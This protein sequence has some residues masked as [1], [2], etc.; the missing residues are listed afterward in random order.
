MRRKTA[1]NLPVPKK[2][3]FLRAMGEFAKQPVFM[4]MLAAPIIGGLAGAVES[5]L[6]QARQ[7]KL[8][9]QSYKTMLELH[10][11]L[12]QRNQ[13]EV[14]RIYSSLHNASPAMASDPMVAG[15]WVDNIVE[16]KVP[17]MNSHQGLLNAVKDLA[18][19]QWQVTQARRAAAGDNR[20]RNYTENQILNIGKGV[21][22]VQRN[23][24]DES[25]KAHRADLERIA[26]ENNETFTQTD[27]ALDELRAKT[28][29]EHEDLQALK[30]GLR[31][32]A[33]QH[34]LPVPMAKMG[35]PDL[36]SLLRALR[37]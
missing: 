27:R 17:G 32:Y 10:P 31:D 13:G 15:A 35:S 6:H 12:R 29:K 36:K 1:T 23:S 25:Y 16:N 8:K 20:M 7:S 3:T 19:T 34:R 30:E 4:S 33:K 26:E 11:H 28:R 22:E 9:A 5:Q 37:V 2:Q 14:H 21:A 18:A 24:L